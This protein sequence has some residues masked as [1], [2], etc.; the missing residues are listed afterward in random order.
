[1][2]VR[3]LPIVWTR[4]FSLWDEPVMTLGDIMLTFKGLIY[5]VIGLALALW[6]LTRG[7]PKINGIVPVQGIPL[8]VLGGIF[9]FFSI[10]PTGVM[11]LEKRILFMIKYKLERG[12]VQKI[13]DSGETLG[14]KLG[15]KKEGLPELIEVEPTPYG[16][17]SDA[18]RDGILMKYTLF[19]NSIEK[20]VEIIPYARWKKYKTS[21]LE[22]EVLETDFFMKAHDTNIVD[23]F[24][25]RN[26]KLGRK[27]IS[28]P[29]VK[30]VEADHL[31][32]END[33]YVRTLALASL[34]ESTIEGAPLM[35]Y[36]DAIVS[37]MYIEPVPISKA[38][39]YINKAL[40][41]M[42]SLLSEKVNLSVENMYERLRELAGSVLRGEKVHKFYCTI[43][44]VADSKEMLDRITEDV[45]AMAKRAEMT[46]YV[47]K[48]V[49]HYLY[50]G[51]Y[52]VMVGPVKIQVIDPV[53]IN[54]RSLALFYPFISDE[55][56]D[57]NGILLG[58]NP[59]SKKPIIYN[60]FSRNNTNITVLG[61]SGSGK[62]MTTKVFIK[63]WMTE[64]PETKLYIIDPEGEYAKSAERLADNIR[65]ITIKPNEY[66]GIDPI[67]MA[68][69]GELERHTVAEIIADMYHMKD[70][71]RLI[72]RNLVMEAESIEHLVELA[73]E[74]LGADHSV[75][76]KLRAALTPPDIYMF[77]GEFKAIGDRVIFDFSKITN[78]RQKI[79]AATLVASYLSYVV[80]TREDPETPKLLVVDEGWRFIQMPS[81]MQVLDDVARRG[82]KRRVIFMFVTQRPWDVANNEHG[83]SILE[84]SDTALLLRQKPAATQLLKEI[85]FL[86]DQEVDTL[87][88]AQPGMGILRA[89]SVKT[90][91][92]VQL[93]EEE[94]NAFRT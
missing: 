48:Y 51:I 57:I 15:K 56:R 59:E 70:E 10:V 11:P 58:I 17:L 87:L 79:L 77:K 55:L 16:L 88:H 76:V 61:E 27:D 93:S 28:L 80:L 23:Q 63:R 53:I 5:M 49:Q 2:K 20:P 22:V 60:P 31:V 89:G 71:E 6:G 7:G 44:L 18:D 41:R 81:I 54:S 66:I 46:F 91:I 78:N 33:L 8:M 75:T 35:F 90:P 43:T 36:P 21:D 34:G 25:P 4:V 29:R 14:K 64:H 82:R 86:N 39:G 84:N 83:R 42:N 38:E 47:P 26:K 13:Y 94:M 32:L 19:L 68:S 30:K 92:Y 12:K 69:N 73:E 3:R 45:I 40:M 65:V 72:V 67:K 52:E 74:R 37:R 50:E 1:M 9:M 24:F 62:S 85:F